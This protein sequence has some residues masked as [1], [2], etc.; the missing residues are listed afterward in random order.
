MI[1]I[2]TFSLDLGTLF[3]FSFLNSKIHKVIYESKGNL[4]E[5]KKKK[6]IC[7]SFPIEK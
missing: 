1:P 5:K 2:H 7:Y 4:L 3:F 6:S